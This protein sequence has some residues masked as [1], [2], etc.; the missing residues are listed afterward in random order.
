MAKIQNAKF[1]KG[2][3]HDLRFLLEQSF[4]SHTGKLPET[5]SENRTDL[6]L[7]L[8]PDLLVEMKCY[9]AVLTT[10]TQTVIKK[11]LK[12]LFDHTNSTATKL[13]LYFGLY[14][15]TQLPSGKGTYIPTQRL[16]EI[17]EEIDKIREVATAENIAIDSYEYY[18]KTLPDRILYSVWFYLRNTTTVE[19]VNPA[20]RGPVGRSGLA[21]R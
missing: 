13:F 18:D 19:P 16:A 9:D 10:S 14:G 4:Y 1:A 17:K 21:F 11:D 20:D 12:S 15:K 6:K 8:D 7:P 2:I 5:E 3:E